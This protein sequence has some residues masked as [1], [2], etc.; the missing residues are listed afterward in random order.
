MQEAKFLSNTEMSW[1]E[2]VGSL[3]QQ[4]AFLSLRS[5]SVV[6]IR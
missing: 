5:P 3:K 4:I 2:I 6:S 1:D